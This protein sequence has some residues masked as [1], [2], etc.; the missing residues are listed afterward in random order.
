MIQPQRPNITWQL[1]KM[2]HWQQK[3]RNLWQ[4][5]TV[6]LHPQF[7]TKSVERPSAQNTD[8][9]TRSWLFL[10]CNLSWSTSHIKEWL[11][12]TQ[13]KSFAAQGETLRIVW[14]TVKKMGE[15][16]SFFPLNVSYGLTCAHLTCWSNRYLEIFQRK[17]LK[18]VCVI[19]FKNLKHIE[20]LWLANIF[21]LPL[22]LEL[23]Y[24]L[25]LSTKC[26]KT[27]W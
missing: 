11:R 2:V 19:P 18:L 17:S 15:C 9:D 12:Y 6:F 22:F 16:T 20:Q 26:Q 13:K 3:R 7:R 23:N 5:R 27:S 25:F 14:E 21:L 8:N 1:S 4:T 24:I 10:S